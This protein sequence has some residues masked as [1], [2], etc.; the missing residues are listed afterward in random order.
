V[1]DRSD[2]EVC[3]ADAAEADELLISARSTYASGLRSQRG[4]PAE[5]ADRKA[6]EDVAA[7]L[8]DG[9]GTDGHV[10][11]VARDG[12]R[13]VG[14]IWVAVQGPDRPGT[15]WI[16]HVWVEPSARGRR[17][18]RRLIEAAGNTVRERGAQALGLNVFGDNAPAIAV[19]DALG[20]TVTAQQMSLPLG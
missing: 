13:Y 17:V 14:G 19:Y 3:P 18:S 6:A 7:L 16:Y 10:L 5:D 4:F 12:G 9:K 2:V 8:P 15:A 1:A 20:F 11:L